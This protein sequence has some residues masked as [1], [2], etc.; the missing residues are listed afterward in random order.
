MKKQLLYT[1]IFIQL[2]TTEAFSSEQRLQTLLN[3]YHQ[4]HLA[5]TYVEKYPHLKN[6]VLSNGENLTQHFLHQKQYL[7][8]KRILKLNPTINVGFL[9]D[10]LDHVEQNPTVFQKEHFDLLVDCN[11]TLL[12]S[13]N[14]E[15][16]TR[17][18][19]L[20]RSKSHI[21]FNSRIGAPL[22]PPLLYLH[23][24][25]NTT[26]IFT[27]KILP[28]MQ[29]SNN[30][31]AHAFASVTPQNNYP[32]TQYPSQNY[33][34]FQRQDST[35]QYIPAPPIIGLKKDMN[36]MQ[37]QQTQQSYTEPSTTHSAA[38]TTSSRAKRYTHNPYAH[39][40][41]SSRSNHAAGQQ[42]RQ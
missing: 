41:S 37:E 1:F 13:I 20:H 21:D 4:Q 12:T 42:L 11:P 9:P 38:S 29:D 8:L 31:A 5:I 7:F 40:K 24:Q 17:F 34:Q 28:D 27:P 3:D 23:S 15:T 36:Q 2:C 19:N 33:I 35:I 16:R 10:F 32:H 6:T 18:N 30:A 25:A 26:S 39:I 22:L 14:T